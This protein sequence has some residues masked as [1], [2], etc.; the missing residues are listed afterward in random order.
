MA[1][2]MSQ[3]ELSDTVRALIAQVAQ[4]S[5]A[6]DTANTKLDSLQQTC[7]GAWTRISERI[8]ATEVKMTYFMDN[9]RGNGGKTMKLVNE[10]AIAPTV[11]SN[12]RKDWTTW[13]RTMKAYLDCRYSGFRK[14]LK[15]AETCEEE[16]TLEMIDGT[17]WS[18]ARE[19]NGQLCNF[20]LTVT[21][22][23]AQAM[24]NN[25][26][27]T[28]GYE[29]WR[30]IAQFYD[31]PG[32]E[33]ELDKINVLLNTT[34]CTTLAKVVSTVETWGEGLESLRGEDQGGAA[35]EMEGQLAAPNDP[36]E[37]RAGYP[38]SLRT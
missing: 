38:T 33:G 27:P 35:R 19:S 16:V 30:K 10:T 37:L 9:V 1:G 8:D 11:Y 15:W 31:P 12:D 6:L 36:Q 34:R 23:E 26:D 2:M 5:S 21:K 14:M 24:I 25:M 4:L 18:Y 22:L 3:Q 32:G 13:S 29:C 28:M 7:D 20:L 17:G